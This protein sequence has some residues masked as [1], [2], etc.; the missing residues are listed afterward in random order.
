MFKKAYQEGRRVLRR[1]VDIPLAGSVN[2]IDVGSYGGLP[3]PWSIR[4][5]VL[6]HAL[7]FD[8]REPDARS[9]RQRTMNVALWDENGERDFYIRESFKGTGSSFFETNTEWVKEHF[10]ELKQRGNPWYAETFF[11]RGKVVGIEKTMCRRLDDVLA[12]LDW[13]V[14]FDFLK[15]DAQ[16]AE[17]RILRGAEALLRGSCV[18]LHVEL[19]LFPIMKGIALKDEVVGYLRGFGFEIAREYPP[20]ATF[21]CA[22]D[23]IFLKEGVSSKAMRAIRRVYG[24]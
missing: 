10:D 14:S 19:F 21:D 7:S 24:F 5:Y 11:E 15:I 13:D 16:G 6:G 9:E 18:G 8:P 22:Q 20:D 1:I 4:P 3:F 2:F 23:V 12:E 17:Y